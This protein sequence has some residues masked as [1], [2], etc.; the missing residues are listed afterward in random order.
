MNTS[1]AATTE[2][3]THITA[4]DTVRGLAALFHRLVEVPSRA[5]GKSLPSGLIF[6]VIGLVAS[7]LLSMRL[8]EWSICK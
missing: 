8:G 5:L 4:F 6:F 1:P 2:S 3:P 7:Q